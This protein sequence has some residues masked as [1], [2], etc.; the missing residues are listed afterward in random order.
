MMTPN[1][2]AT[3]AETKAP[4]KVAREDQR[5][6]M[7]VETLSA[8]TAIKPIFLILLYTLIWSK[9][10]AKDQMASWEIHQLLEEVEEDQE[11]IHTKDSI[12]EQ[13]TSLR[14]QKE[15]EVQ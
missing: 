8:S 2:V 4:T 9:N 12:L 6:T 3:K 14:L 7:L 11:R 5:T 15:K 10:T 13:R 1:K